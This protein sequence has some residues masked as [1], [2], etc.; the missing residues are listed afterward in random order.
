M[1]ALSHNRNKTK[2][3]DRLNGECATMFVVAKA[4]HGVA[5]FYL[6]EMDIPIMV[7]KQKSLKYFRVN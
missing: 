2:K 6:N 4:L 7:L 1:S 5:M 3:L